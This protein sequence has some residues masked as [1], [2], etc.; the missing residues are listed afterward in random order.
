MFKC[1][2]QRI[3]NYA[4]DPDRFPVRRC[5]RGSFIFI[6]INKTGGTSVGRALGL[7]VKQHLTARQV[8][9]I[10]GESNWR[11]AYRFSVVRNPWDKVVSHYKY[12][13]KTNQT[14][15]AD[16][17]ISFKDWVA[18]TYGPEKRAPY[19]DNPIMFQ[20][21]VDWLQDAGGRIDLDLIGRFEDLHCAY[22]QV[23]AH[24]GAR[25][26]LPHLNQTMR[27]DYRQYYDVSTAEMVGAWFREDVATFG[28]QF[29]N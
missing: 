3:A 12:R 20:P 17:P 22:R 16:R 9:D 19:Y 4:I 14:G 7:P 8:I 18:A 15:M 29:D 1:L 2:W 24:V 10:V 27:E 5:P 28:Y 21:Q 25:A 6:H 23:A 13:V 26:E 11:R